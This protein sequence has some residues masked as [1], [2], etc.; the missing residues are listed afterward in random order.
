MWE[1]N[2]REAIFCHQK[3]A[4]IQQTGKQQKDILE[5]YFYVN[6]SSTI[7]SFQFYPFLC[8]IIIYYHNKLLFMRDEFGHRNQFTESYTVTAQLRFIF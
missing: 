7:V 6:A 2:I 5:E 1:W 3:H 4:S 8:I